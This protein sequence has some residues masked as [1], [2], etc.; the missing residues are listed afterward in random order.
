M[1][2][3]SSAVPIAA[4]TDIQLIRSRDNNRTAAVCEHFLTLLHSGHKVVPCPHSFVSPS[5][6][7]VL[8][9]LEQSSDT[10]PGSVSA[11]SS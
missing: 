8:E 9:L 5:P 7:R 11:G 10:L 1:H 3:D 2:N 6:T 4:K